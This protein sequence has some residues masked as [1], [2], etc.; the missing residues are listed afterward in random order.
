MVKNERNKKMKNSITKALTLVIALAL[1]VCGA[2]AISASA[3]NEASANIE[4]VTL[5]YGGEVRIAYTL[6]LSGTTAE[7]VVLKIYDNP[8]LTGDPYVSAFSGDYYEEVSPIYYSKGV[9]A[10]DLADYMWAVPCDKASGEALGRACRYSVAHYCYATLADA[11][12]DEDLKILAEDLLAYGASAQTRLINIGNIASEPLVTDYNYVYT[13][14]SGVTLDGYSSGLYAPD[15][16]VIPSYSGDK[17]ISSWTVTNADGTSYSVSISEAAN[18]FTVEQ[19]AIIAPEFE[20]S[21]VVAD[22]SEGFIQDAPVTSTKDDEDSYANIADDATSHTGTEIVYE[23]ADPL[24]GTNNALK[25]S[26]T[27]VKQ[28]QAGRT[29]VAV[30]GEGNCYV[31]ETDIYIASTKSG[32]FTRLNFRDTEG[33][34][35]ARFMLCGNGQIKDYNTDTSVVLC[36][37]DKNEWVTLRIEY[38]KSSVA[39]ENSYKIFADGVLIAQS[40]G[41]YKV[42]DAPI[43]VVRLQHQRLSTYVTYYD[44]MSAYADVKSYT[45]EAETID[46]EDN[47]LTG[48]LYETRD[49]NNLIASGNAVYEGSA[50]NYSITADPTDAANKVLKVNTFNT[51][52]SGVF[53]GYTG[54]SVQKTDTLHAGNCTVFESKIYIE[55]PTTEDERA[56]AYL[57]FR[58]SGGSVFYLVLT[59]SSDGKVT[60]KN[61]Q[62]AEDG[63]NVPTTLAT[64]DTGKWM[65]IRIETYKSTILEENY[66]KVY[67]GEDSEN[68]TLAAAIAGYNTASLATDA[69]AITTVRLDYYRKSALNMYFDD[70]CVYDQNKAFVNEGASLT[71]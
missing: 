20:I 27:G 49:T 3:D 51:S 35:V 40:Y 21:K 64:F 56:A 58:N 28:K 22:F 32:E 14:T 57:Y 42:S 15:A 36:T 8:A 12:A 6:S 23:I 25:V 41:A 26:S 38:Y 67:I 7:N 16:K 44:N 31:F 43:S 71:E 68:M 47:S 53:N 10:K 33:N 30:S 37:I 24:G 39:E 29:D 46:F 70:V 69:N 4:L 1:L 66:I 62:K 55:T 17:T 18:G 5:N 19:N 63:T 65:N 2:F 61:Y 13:K 54:Y 45:P 34:A 52:E 48:A 50:A 9:S 59:T 60:L 11:S